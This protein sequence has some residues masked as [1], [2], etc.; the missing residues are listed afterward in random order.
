MRLSN[1]ARVT[2]LCVS[3]NHNP[4]PLQEFDFRVEKWES[5]LTPLTRKTKIAFP[6]TSRSQRCGMQINEILFSWRSTSSIITALSCGRLE[7]ASCCLARLRPWNKNEPVDQLCVFLW[8][9]D[10]SGQ[11]RLE[12]LPAKHTRLHVGILFKN[13]SIP[14][15]LGCAFRKTVKLKN[16]IVLFDVESPKF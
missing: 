7:C 15:F 2:Q 8:L 12:L 4:M 3:Y 6:Q 5:W 9:D 11:D 1:S 16:R 13:D 14:E 10:P